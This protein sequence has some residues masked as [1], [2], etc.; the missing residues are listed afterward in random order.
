MWDGYQKISQ[1]CEKGTRKKTS[2]PCEKGT[3]KKPVNHMKMVPEKNQSCMWKGYQKKPVMHVKR[4]PEKMEQ[5]KDLSLLL[6]ITKINVMY[7]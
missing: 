2:Q 4:G 7:L 6:I 5:L 3:R 1:L